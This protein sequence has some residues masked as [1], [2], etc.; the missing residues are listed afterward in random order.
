MLLGAGYLVAVDTLARTIAPLEIPLGVLTAFIGAPFFIWLLAASRRGWRRRMRLDVQDRPSATPARRWAAG[1][2]SA[3]AGGEVLCLL[4]PNGGG[5]TT[6]LQDHPALA[7]PRGR[8][9]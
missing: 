2:A 4:G 8:A 7:R 5:K 9:A 1:Y 3:C 6:L